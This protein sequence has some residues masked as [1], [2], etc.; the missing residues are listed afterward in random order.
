M[1]KQPLLIRD[2]YNF[3]PPPPKSRE[4]PWEKLYRFFFGDDVF[5][6]YSRADAIRY[7]PSLAACL[8]EKRHICFFDQLAADPSED[9]PRRLKKKILRSTVFVLVGTRGAVASSA[10]RKEVELF[11]RTRRPFIP[12]DVDGALVEQEGW[13]DVVGVAK[14]R[15]DGA[16]VRA[17][18]PSPEVVS[19]I[20]D[21]FRYTRR[22]H[23]LRASLLAGVSVVLLTAA[24]S[25]L[26]IDAARAEAASIRR[27]ADSDVA[28]AN[29]KVVEAEQR[30]QSLTADAVLSRADA[31]KARAAADAAAAATQTAVT[32]QKAAEQAAR[33]AHE[34]ERQSAERAA[35]SLR[36]VAGS[37]AALI[38][39]EYGME[40]DALALALGAAE[41][42]LSRR[43]GLSGQVLAGLAAAATAAD[44]SLPL[45]SVVPFSYPSTQVSPDGE[46][47]FAI[48][49]DTVTVSDR[50]VLWDVRTGRQTDLTSKMDSVAH[51]S[52]SRDGGRLAIAS[53][54]APDVWATELRVWDL[55]GPEPKLLET[56][57]GRRR[58][59]IHQVA[60]DGDGSHAAIYEWPQSGKAQLALCEIATGREEVLPLV[61]LSDEGFDVSVGGG[62]AFTAEDEPAIYAITRKPDYGVRSKVIYFP[63]TGR[64][65]TLKT[66][67]GQ[68]GERLAGF[69]DDGSVVILKTRVTPNYVTDVPDRVVYIQSPDG[70][71]R[72]LSGYRGSVQSTSVSG[73]L[74]R[75]VTVGGGRMRLADVYHSPSF[76]VL[77][78][79]LHRLNSVF[80]SPD[81]ETVLTVGGDDTVRLWDVRTGA[82]RHTLALSSDQPD[83]DR[84]DSS[85]SLS[86]VAF[87]PDGSRVV[88]AKHGAVQVWDVK[89]GRPT[90][91]GFGSVLYAR[92]PSMDVA[93]VAGGD[94]VMAHIWRGVNEG[95]LVTFMDARTCRPAGAFEF[96]RG[97]GFLSFSADGA[98]ILTTSWTS[99]GGWELKFWSLLGLEFKEG[100]LMR[101]SVSSLGRGPGYVL[102]GSSAGGAL[103]LVDTLRDGVHVWERGATKGVR[104]EGLQ[105]NLYLYRS[106]R[107][108]FSADGTRVAVV[109]NTEA[110]L[111]DAHSGKLLM[112]FPCE[113]DASA[114]HPVSLSPDGSKLLIAGTDHTAR[115]Y[116]TS[117]EGFLVAAKRLLGR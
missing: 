75:V 8:A 87:L 34:L 100:A 2:A 19:L 112:A 77:R 20:N 73:A 39:R 76:A 107:T 63:R 81:G 99:G 113:A 47:V 110:R 58:A 52:F 92:P 117:P 24:A 14:I 3:G 11:R 68:E 82:L 28:A 40:T 57:C 5:I 80:F 106:F 7:V 29:Q 102:S 94:Y 97:E 1:N 42:S 56:G 9:L 79:H 95:G 62:L 104:L 17:G 54:V 90:C 111:W 23:W 6:S 45:A 53:T 21:S 93:F 98:G 16:R 91:P 115:I 83:D 37:R 51:A 101:P 60:L 65:V 15:E 41:E 116:P 43:G 12:V 70:N 71:L 67:G 49:R 25:L 4:A 103:M 46:K 31:E 72:K 36:Q 32:Q 74:A 69:G 89:T 78:G 26:V 105:S 48:F 55:T 35:E 50:R 61:Y 114:V 109:T 33:R 85:P 84:P 30:L 64:A 38:S 88:T 108:S 59:T 66:P 86:Y 96:S 10:V 27:Q 18:D 13:R 22:S 44:Y